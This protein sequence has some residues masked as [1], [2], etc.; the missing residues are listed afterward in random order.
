MCPRVSACACVRVCACACVRARS[1]VR[2][3]VCVGGGVGCTSLPHIVENGPGMA[4][5][6]T[7]LANANT[8]LRVASIADLYYIGYIEIYSCVLSMFKYSSR[9]L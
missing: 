6:K 1:C 9:I 4:C 7:Y 5:I 8:L 3:R 2:V